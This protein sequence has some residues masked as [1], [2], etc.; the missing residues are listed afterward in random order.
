M[1]ANRLV[2]DLQ[3]QEDKREDH[4]GDEPG[5]AVVVSDPLYAFAELSEDRALAGGNQPLNVP[6]GHPNF[7]GE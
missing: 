5:V 1:V 4:D 3:P 6:L 7:L 2:I